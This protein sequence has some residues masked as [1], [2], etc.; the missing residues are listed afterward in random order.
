MNVGFMAVLC[1][2]GENTIEFK[3]QT[4]YLALGVKITGAALLFFAGYC[5]VCLLLRHRGKLAVP[6]Y[7][8]GEKL[9]QEWK[10]DAVA[11][12][13]QQPPEEPEPT[14]DLLAKA[15]QDL[16]HDSYYTP[17]FEQGFFVVTQQEQKNGNPLSGRAA[18]GTNGALNGNSD[19]SANKDPNTNGDPSGNGN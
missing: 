18:P 5:L 11:E 15:A 1:H 14:T 10:A 7:P 13:L 9:L 4:P 8:E 2:A 3:Y 12:K 19:P 16:A 6:E 17:D